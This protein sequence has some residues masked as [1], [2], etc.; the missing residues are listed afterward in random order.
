MIPLVE[1]TCLVDAFVALQADQFRFGGLR[2]GAGQFGLTHTGRAF[3]Q[4]RLAEPV[5]EEYR[6]GGGG[7]GQVAGFGQPTT[8]IVDI[9]E[10]RDR[11]RGHT[12]FCVLLNTSGRAS[13][14]VS[15]DDPFG[16]GQFR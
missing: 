7:I 12:H 4:K 16:R 2:D 15:P 11:P 10:Q 13:L 8:D 3:H 5:G 6:G 1:R 9:G 14:T